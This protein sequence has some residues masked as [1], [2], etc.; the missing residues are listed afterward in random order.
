MHTPVRIHARVQD[1]AAGSPPGLDGGA[2]S[3]STKPALQQSA[4]GNDDGE[5]TAAEDVQADGGAEQAAAD[6]C[7]AEGDLHDDS[8]EATPVRS[9]QSLL[10][11]VEAVLTC[12]ELLLGA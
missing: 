7:E 6:A 10:C 8:A 4:N 11:C 2:Q 9:V 1:S 12:I 3:D 5:H